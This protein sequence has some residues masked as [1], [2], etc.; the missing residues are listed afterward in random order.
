VRE[1]MQ[2]GRKRFTIAHEIGHFILP[3]HDDESRICDE[4]EIEVPA[5]EANDEADKE[6]NDL[7]RAANKFAAELLM[8]SS[9]IRRIVTKCGISIDTCEFVS[10]LFQVSLTAAAARSVEE[11]PEYLRAALVVS[12]KGIVKYFVKSLGSSEYIEIDRKIP[13][14]SLAKQLSEHGPLRKKGHVPA[15]VWID[16]KPGFLLQEESVLLPGY[17]TVLTLITP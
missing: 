4:E 8:P 7:E 16:I 12:K 17:E 2:E 6:N 13:V 3:G 11:T 5:D 10:D 9:A 14:G 15:E 1:S